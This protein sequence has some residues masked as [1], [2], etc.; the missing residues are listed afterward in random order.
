M[1]LGFEVLGV[2]MVERGSCFIS[3]SG[4]VDGSAWGWLCWTSFADPIFLN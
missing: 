1:G 2:E 3:L 4:S